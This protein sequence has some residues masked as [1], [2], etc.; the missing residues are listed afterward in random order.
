M[1]KSRIGSFCDDLRFLDGGWITA[2]VGKSREGR[3]FVVHIRFPG[4]GVLDAV[5]FGGLERELQAFKEVVF[6]DT[7]HTVTLNFSPHGL[8]GGMLSFDVNDFSPEYREENLVEVLWKLVEILREAK[9][10][11]VLVE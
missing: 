3:L 4:R 1:R 8:R 2:V 7:L 11:G 5:N 9:D 6:N 10:M